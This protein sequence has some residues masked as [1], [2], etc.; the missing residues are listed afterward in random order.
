MLLISGINNL[1][2]VS[3]YPYKV[4]VTDAN[5]KDVEIY[6]RGDERLKY[7]LSSDG[8][9]LINDIDG[10]WYLELIDSCNVSKSKFRLVAEEDESIELKQ[11]KLGCPK[12]LAPLRESYSE[13]HK[14][15]SLTKTSVGGE[16]IGERRALVILMEYKDLKFRKSREDF[17]ELFNAVDYKENDSRGSV[18]DYYRFASQGQLDYV[19]DV[20]GPYTSQHPMSYYGANSMN[21]GGDLRPLELCIEAVKSLPSDLDYSLYDNDADGLI[22]NVHIIYAGY[23][24]EAGASSDAIWAHEYPYKIPLKSEVGYSLEGYSCSPELRG[25]RGTGITNIGVICHELGHALGAMDYYDTNYGVGGEY[26]GTGDW[27]IMASGSWNDDGRTPPN[28]NPYVRSSV[29]GWNDQV[30]LGV[31]EH[32]TM[33][34]SD[35]NNPKQ[36]IIYRMETGSYGDYF[37]LENRQ[38]YSFDAALPGEGLLIYHVHPNIDK[39]TET[40]TVNATHPQCFYPV[41]A[42]YSNPNSKKYGNINTAECPF[43]G[44]KNV[45]QFS[46]TTSPSAVAWNGSA[47]MVSITNITKNNDGSLTFSTGE[48]Y[49]SDPELP[50][51]SVEMDLIYKESFEENISDRI[52][53]NSIIGKEVWKSYKKG[54]FVLNADYFPNATDGRRLLMLYSDKSNIWSE[55]EAIG[56]ELKIE[57][58]NNYTISFDIYSEVLS[59]MQAPYFYLSVENEYGENIIYTLSKATSGWKTVE[60]PLVLTGN[61]VRYKLYGRILI[62]GLFVDNFK[63]YREKELDSIDCIS[64]KEEDYVL[65][66]L[67]GTF[68]NKVDDNSLSGLYI[69]KQGTRIKKIVIK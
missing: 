42:S 21:G 13:V 56:P 49:S 20:Y 35:I 43:P 28:F 69:L 17:L 68:M 22:D 2:A 4:I 32:I 31:N 55:S 50:D 9:T 63:M 54:D 40:N 67:D 33:P 7:A 10:W 62:G 23:G 44:S 3:A 24:E 47:S 37:L 46:P 14:V 1:F 59:K 39:Y 30:V 58:G 19:S 48:D 45:R 61:K 11:F 36:S 27:D 38:Q 64:D 41:C 66:R 12:G 8:Y 57:S 53:T 18:R 26:L 16:M 6:M 60:I 15:A 65:Y 34:Q 29:F 51:S 5:G 25:N 52:V